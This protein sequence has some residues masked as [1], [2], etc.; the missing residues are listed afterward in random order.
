MLDEFYTTRPL[1]KESE[2][3]FRIIKNLYKGYV[4]R[5]SKDALTRRIWNFI[6]RGR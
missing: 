5:T 4:K 2:V 3:K 6:Q 1:C